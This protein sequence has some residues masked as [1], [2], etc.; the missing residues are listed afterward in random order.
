MLTREGCLQRRANLWKQ[1]PESV[2]WVLIGDARHIQY[3]SNFH[4]NPLSFSADQRA[5]LL[6][7]RNAAS[8]LTDNFVRASSESE[9]FVDNDVVYDWYT[10]KKTVGNR[11]HAL[12]EA[13]KTCRDR[14]SISKGLIESE[15]V[16][17]LVAE[18]V[19][20]ES[21][22]P[23]QRTGHSTTIGNVVRMLR[24][25]KLPDEVELLRLCTAASDA[26]QLAAFD[27]VKPGATEI[28][29]YL[30]I[31]QAVEQQAG[32]A[33]VIYGDFRATN[34][35]QFNAGGLPT[36]YQ[37]RDGDL[38]IADF[39]VVL[40]G[41]R[42]D[43]TNTM[44]VGNPTAEQIRAFE[45]CRDALVSAAGNL[46]SGVAAQDIYMASSQVFLERGYSPLSHH[47]GHGLGL[48]HPEPPI[49]VPESTDRLLAGDVVT[50]EPGLYVEG[51]GGMRFEHNYLVKPDGCEQL[52]Q[53][54]I[55][56]TK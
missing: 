13:L 49:L 14:W 32:R 3:F 23:D 43:V 47:C 51:V 17:Q 44:A 42:S 15:G 7:E 45:T 36:S 12:V 38:F 41:Y 27:L 1:M 46:Q 28:E 53:H 19:A 25:Q 22:F 20:G 50:I 31:R 8:L 34:G 48:E 18:T 10:H 24:R 40:N 11:D 37:L 6:L 26:G 2:E 55:G 33:C 21:K 16:T 30:A 9:P 56:L 39:S 5:L 4:I 52:S 35:G 29:V 54:H